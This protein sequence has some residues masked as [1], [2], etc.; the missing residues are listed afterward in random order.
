M[1]IEA[2]FSILMRVT[3]M[4]SGI[5]LLGPAIYSWVSETPIS[6]KLKGLILAACAFIIISGG[7]TLMIKT[8]TPAGYHMWFGI[9]LLLVM[10]IIAVHFMMAIQDMPDAKK[11]RMAK[12]IAM[13]G[14][15]VVILS[16][17]MLGK[18]LRDLTHNSDAIGKDFLF[19]DDSGRRRFSSRTF[20]PLQ[21]GMARQEH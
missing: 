14:I 13:S 9:K 15:V 12:G 16:L 19:E 7:Y 4:L 17:V 11:V 6:K 10:H 1:D 5:V 21:S 8:V 18:G 3:H 20:P 2:L